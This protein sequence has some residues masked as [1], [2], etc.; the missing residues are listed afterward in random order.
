MKFFM[1]FLLIFLVPV[2]S[3]N[4]GI[5]DPMPLSGIFKV[6]CVTEKKQNAFNDSI[7]SLNSKFLSDKYKNNYDNVVLTTQIAIGI[8]ALFVTAAA[9]LLSVWAYINFKAAKLPKKKF[10]KIN[11]EIS[12]LKNE[13]YNKLNILDKRI[14]KNEKLK[15]YKAGMK[16]NEQY[17]TF[18]DTRDGRVYRTVKIGNQIW[19]AENFNL[20][21]YDG[22]VIGE[23]Y[24]KDLNIGAIHGR[25]YDW[26]TAKIIA[27]PEW[28]LPSKEEWEELVDF[29]GGYDVSGKKLKAKVGW[30][31]NERISGNGTDDFGFAAFPSGIC[32]AG[33]FFANLNYKGVWWTSTEMNP[34]TAYSR[35]IDHNGNWTFLGEDIKANLLSVRYVKD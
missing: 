28:H 8:A 5:C 21:E 33:Q 27:P 35:G 1:F 22:K 23:Y 17:S 31:Y 30:A 24:N 18:T 11:K 16:R 7:D 32:F 9:V 19:M 12:N 26:E 25:L 20:I 29:A 15:E 13:I 10:K 6:V 2:W 14:E 34:F 3:A 4:N